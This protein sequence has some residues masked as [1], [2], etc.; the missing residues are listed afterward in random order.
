MWC[1]DDRSRRPTAGQLLNSEFMNDM[2]S[3]NNGKPCEVHEHVKIKVFRKK[4]FTK[5]QLAEIPE[6]E[7]RED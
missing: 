7:A 3:E 1:L 6:E 4:L 2:T 5:N